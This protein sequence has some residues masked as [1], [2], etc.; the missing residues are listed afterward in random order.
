MAKNDIT[1]LLTIILLTVFFNSALAK[2]IYSNNGQ[3]SASDILKA[4][5]IGGGLFYGVSYAAGPVIMGGLEASTVVL[6]ASL[7]SKI[8]R[9]NSLTYLILGTLAAI[10]LMHFD[11]EDR[12]K[13]RQE[14]GAING[15][16]GALIGAVS[17]L[18]KE[19]NQVKNNTFLPTAIL[20]SK[21][22]VSLKF[23]FNLE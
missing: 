21:K 18:D 1:K 9:Y 23:T 3:T 16:G 8:N 12:Y 19:D 11:P 4:A 10:N 14:V 17:S 6:S 22:T 13:K 5:A 2:D 20:F 7:K 15:I